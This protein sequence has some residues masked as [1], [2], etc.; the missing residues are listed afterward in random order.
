MQAQALLNEINSVLNIHLTLTGP[1][2]E[3]LV[4]EFENG[5]PVHPILLGQSSTPAQKAQLEASVPFHF[6]DWGPDTISSHVTKDFEEKI[7]QSVATIKMKKRKDV[8]REVQE[9]R[10]KRW[11]DCLGRLQACFGLR[12]PP[13][14]NGEQPSFASGQI[15][16][17]DVLNPVSFSFH[18]API[19]I[20]IDVEWNECYQSQLTEVG[21]STLDMMDLRNVAPGD[22]GEMWI[23]QIRSRHLR[24]NEYRNWVNWRYVQGCPTRFGFGTSEMV[25]NA[26][27]S[28]VVDAAFHPPYMVAS[29]G[30]RVARYKQKKRTVILVGLNLHNDLDILRA[31]NCQVFVNLNGPSSVIRE[32]VDVGE[33][34][35][36]EHR[37][38][39]LRGL[40]SLLGSLNILS[41]NLHNAG[42]DASYT[43]QAL[44]RLMLRVAGEK[45]G[46]YE[47][48]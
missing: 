32:V 10:K 3:G 41:R 46:A 43:L 15:E 45:H 37:E 16:P 2:K 4:V 14:A 8:N 23:S 7:K 25:P 48:V 27:I 33:L 29:N 35:R 22:Y 19:F 6:E 13:Q 40:E 38:L 31:K 47:R 21:I 1:G 24:V 42:N 11:E 18:D 30:E 39:Q 20:S 26:E 12:P 36:V 44:V 17:I 28:E 34:Y 5:T 9:A